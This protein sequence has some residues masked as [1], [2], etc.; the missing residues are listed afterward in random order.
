VFRA[1]ALSTLTEMV[2]LEAFRDRAEALFVDRPIDAT[3]AIDRVAVL[4]DFPSPEPAAEYAV[5]LRRT[6]TLSRSCLHES[7]ANSV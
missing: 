6:V 7:D 1:N 2:E 4:I 3:N 5:R